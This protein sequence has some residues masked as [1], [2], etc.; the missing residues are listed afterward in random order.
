MLWGFPTVLKS[1][2]ENWK[3]CFQSWET[4][5]EGFLKPPQKASCLV[6]KLHIPSTWG[7]CPVCPI[8]Q[9]PIHNLFP[10][11]LLFPCYL[12][13]L[14]SIELPN[15]Q[16]PIFFL[17]IFLFL[18]FSWD[19]FMVQPTTCLLETPETSFP[20]MSTSGTFTNVYKTRIC[21][22]L[23]NLPLLF[24]PLHVHVWSSCHPYW[25]S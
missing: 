25:T 13:I 22:V 12:R 1:T 16:M 23:L 19:V 14:S 20:T 9:Q 3:Y 15:N 7:I 8:L 6:L 21:F 5:L 24:L 17:I 2:L 11:S 4:W 18:I 10:I